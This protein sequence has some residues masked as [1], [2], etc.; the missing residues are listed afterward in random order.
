MNG[1]MPGERSP[2]RILMQTY[3][4]PPVHTL[5]ADVTV[6]RS[7][8]G[9]LVT[10]AGELDANL[11]GPFTAVVGLVQR[12]GL[13]VEVDLGAVQ[14]LGSQGVH[15]LLAL[16]DAAPQ[17]RF[18]VRSL[19]VEASATLAACDIQLPTSPAPEHA[20]D[21]AGPAGG[22]VAAGTSHPDPTRTTLVEERA[23][24][25][26]EMHDLVA[27]ST[28]LDGFVQAAADTVARRLGASGV[29]LAVHRPG[30]PTVVSRQPEVLTSVIGLVR[31][32]G[33]GARVVLNV[34]GAG[35]AERRV[36]ERAEMYADVIARAVP[37]QLRLSDQA[38]VS[39]DLQAAMESRSVIDQALGVI[40]A[41]NRCT[42]PEAF[43]ILRSASQNRNVKLRDVAAT[44][45][46]N[47][48]GTPPEPGVFRPRGHHDDAR[49]A[50]DSPTTSRPGPSA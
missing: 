23:N 27:S 25:T 40:M 33:D 32:L 6:S 14:L 20:P 3:L 34:Y 29:A 44:I 8:G 39:A 28:S 49:E 1:F 21:P 46:E 10:F 17:G 42:R 50:A 45:I 26:V 12:G 18:T 4:L 9:V 43:K 24:A 5:C 38:Q 15:A 37:L 7:T 35:A 2:P 11:A 16:R 36:A 22:E 48:V 13:P 41:E 47:L 19:S 31:L 30:G